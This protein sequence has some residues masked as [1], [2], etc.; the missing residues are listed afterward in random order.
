M[1]VPI[2]I[3]AV[4]PFGNPR[5]RIMTDDRIVRTADIYD[6][7]KDARV[8]EAVFS[9]IRPGVTFTEQR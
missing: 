2:L 6:E 9:I 5:R 3:S 7:H 4:C 1:A 8:L